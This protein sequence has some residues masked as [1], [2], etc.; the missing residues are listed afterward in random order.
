MEETLKKNTAT[1]ENAPKYTVRELSDAA[2]TVFGASPDIVTAAL[3]SAGLTEAT[4]EETRKLVKKFM[5]A[6]VPSADRK[7][8][9]R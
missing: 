7:K 2:A 6:P 8:E 4:R 3:K 9:A 5:T 1:E